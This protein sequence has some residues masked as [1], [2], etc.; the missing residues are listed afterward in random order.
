MASVITTRANRLYR[1]T[2][3]AAYA[4]IASGAKRSA[5]TNDHVGHGDLAEFGMGLA[6]DGCILDIR[7]PD[8]DVLD[9][10]RRHLKSLS[11]DQLFQTIDD[12][13]VAFVVLPAQIPGTQPPVNQGQSRR[14]GVLIV[15]VHHLRS[16]NP[17]LPDFVRGQFPAGQGI[18]DLILRVGHGEDRS[19]PP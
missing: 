16:A 19:N 3:S 2:P 12:R 5:G 7:M 8:E 9:L 11:L 17:E 6:D 13:D 18:D 4:M 14:F 1:A 10:G 15:A